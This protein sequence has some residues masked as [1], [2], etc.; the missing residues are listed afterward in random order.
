MGSQLTDS[1][2]DF[3]E[4]RA[5]QLVQK[6]LEA[7]SKNDFSLA[8][9]RFRSASKLNPTAESYTFWGWMEFELGGTQL[10]IQLCQNAIEIDPE[11]G[12]P[13]NDIGSYLV[14]LD[15]L[16][17]SIPYFKKAIQAKRYQP[18]QFPHI[19]LG[20]VYFR[21]KQYFNALKE[22]REARKFIPRDPDI[23]RAIEIITQLAKKT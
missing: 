4:R 20:R 10:A 19:N 15:K 13:Y 2:K 9:D 18:R 7:A 23:S 22:F 8:R 3:Q 11:L 1:K 5:Y 21:K 12:N 14:S 6:G 17:E 16:D